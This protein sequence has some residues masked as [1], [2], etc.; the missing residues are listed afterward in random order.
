[1][2]KDI[3]KDYNYIKKVDTPLPIKWMAIESIGDRV[4]TT[5][6][7]VWSF[8][9][10]LWEIFTLGRSPY[11]GLSADQ[12]F[13]QKLVKGYRM[14]RPDKCP[15]T[16]YEIMT[17][18]WHNNPIARPNF[19][20]LVYKLSE[21]VDESTR[22]HYM[23][24]DASYLEVFKSGKNKTYNYLTMDSSSNLMFKNNSEHSSYMPM[25]SS[26]DHEKSEIKKPSSYNPFPNYDAIRVK[27]ENMNPM[28]VVPMIHFDE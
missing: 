7:D 10:L 1:M 19:K 4:Y 9:I 8:G 2:A 24:L 27:K 23:K 11:P 26:S 25:S 21:M 22:D 13:Y 12:D 5:Q 18:C 16:I 17:D 14:E 6:S 20:Q 3:Q 28:E 15:K